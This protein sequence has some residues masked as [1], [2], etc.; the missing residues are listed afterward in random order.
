MQLTGCKTIEDIKHAKIDH[1]RYS[2]DNLDSNTS[3][4][5]MKPYPKT[6]ENQIKTGSQADAT[7]GASEH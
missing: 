5:R 2:A 1:F 7:S 4:N 3:F 6:S